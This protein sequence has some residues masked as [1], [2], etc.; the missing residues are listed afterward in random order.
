MIAI[1]FLSCIAIDI[2]LL[3]QV[4]SLVSTDVFV[5]QVM[6]CF[7]FYFIAKEVLRIRLAIAWEN[8]KQTE[9]AQN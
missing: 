1:A 5:G 8:S 3:Y 7:S 4:P 2:I 9:P 6:A